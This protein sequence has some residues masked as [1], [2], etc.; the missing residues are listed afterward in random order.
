[1]GIKNKTL[2]LD[3]KL[4]PMAYDAEVI[5]LSVIGHGAPRLEVRVGVAGDVAQM[6]P[7]VGAMIH[8]AELD[9]ADHGAKLGAMNHGAEH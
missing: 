2:A 1:L 3:P 6:W 5:C 8:G 4:G 9:A 7:E